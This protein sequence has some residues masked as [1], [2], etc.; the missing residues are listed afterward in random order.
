MNKVNGREKSHNL[1]NMGDSIKHLSHDRKKILKRGS[2]SPFLPND[3]ST[4]LLNIFNILVLLEK[5]YKLKCSG[6][7]EHTH[8][9]L[10]GL[11]NNHFKNKQVLFLKKQD[12]I[13]KSPTAKLNQA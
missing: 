11:V 5:D 1:R 13:I 9:Q 2:L 6:H 4:Q 7:K 12:R 10:N 3:G 8:P